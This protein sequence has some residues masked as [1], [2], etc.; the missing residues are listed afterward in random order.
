M[1]SLC[2]RNI[3]VNLTTYPAG[4]INDSMS[5]NKVATPDKRYRLRFN[6]HRCTANDM[7]HIATQLWPSDNNMGIMNPFGI[8]PSNRVIHS[9]AD[10]R[11]KRAIVLI[12]FDPKIR[13]SSA[14]HKSGE[15]LNGWV[16]LEPDFDVF[17]IEKERE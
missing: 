6:P 10:E 7:K 4:L 8:S 13:F 3:R 11:K 5:D 9:N 2:M 1:V 15:R 17:G 12:S 16:R 14:D